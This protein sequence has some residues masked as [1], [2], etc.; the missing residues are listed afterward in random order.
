MKIY[1]SKKKITFPKLSYF[2]LC[3]L[4]IPIYGCAQQKTD[5]KKD[6]VKIIEAAKEIIQDANTCALITIDSTGR[7]RVRT[8]DPFPPEDNLVVWFGTNSHSRK[9]QQIQKDNRVTLYY[10]DN[11]ATGYVTIHGTAHLVDDI[12]AKKKRFKDRWKDFY[13]NYPDGYMLIKVHP[14]W[15]EVISETRGIL[16]DKKTWKPQKITFD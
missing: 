11:D 13:P 10:L 9:V 12:T 15:M 8:M 2:V 3:V 5:I 1:L 14:Q 7:P 4:L 6:R 16:G